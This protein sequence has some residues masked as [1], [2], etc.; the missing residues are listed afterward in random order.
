MLSMKYLE[1][2]AD[3]QDP[4]RWQNNTRFVLSMGTALVLIGAGIL[5]GDLA[6]IT[7]GVGLAGLPS[8]LNIAS[9]AT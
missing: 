7:L 5:E 1:M 4:P 2:S 6:L 8:Y 3:L 9:G